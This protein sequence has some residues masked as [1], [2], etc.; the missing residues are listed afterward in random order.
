MLGLGEN[1]DEVKQTMKD[2]FDT[3]CDILT[4][5]QYLMPSLNH[6]KVAKYLT[7]E[8]FYEFKNI[9]LEIG[10][11]AVESGPFVRSSYKAKELYES[12]I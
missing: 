12:L 2:I 3:G 11:K 10:F 5:G 8:E 4:I 7:V 9:A 6:H 1:S